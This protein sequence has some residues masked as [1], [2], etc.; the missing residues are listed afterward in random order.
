LYSN[1]SRINILMSIL[2]CNCVFISLLMF[3]L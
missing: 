3:E 2:Y 1:L